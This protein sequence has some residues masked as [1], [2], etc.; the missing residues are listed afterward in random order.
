MTPRK[1]SGHVKKHEWG[2]KHKFHKA[3][4]YF[5]VN[6]LYY[7]QGQIWVNPPSWEDTGVNR[8][9]SSLSGVA[10]TPGWWAVFNTRVWSQ[11][12]MLT[13]GT[14]DGEKNRG[15]DGSRE[16]GAERVRRGHEEN[17][18][19]VFGSPACMVVA[20][21]T[22]L[23][24]RNERM[25]LCWPTARWAQEA[26]CPLGPWPSLKVSAQEGSGRKT[27]LVHICH[28]RPEGESNKHRCE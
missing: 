27:S 8:E 13:L 5:T 25:T 6:H 10:P 28:Q 20:R 18:T 23:R 21:M 3:A 7:C 1:D 16:H 22:L 15:Q 17:M 24:V 19:W 14:R 26:G 11:V 12:M 2:I 9:A 4:L